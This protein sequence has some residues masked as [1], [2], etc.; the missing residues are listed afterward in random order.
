MVSNRNNI[1]KYIRL[2]RKVFSLETL[3]LSLIIC[4]SYTFHYISG[5]VYAL[6]TGVL[7]IVYILS[8]PT[9]KVKLNPLSSLLLIS[10]FVIVI[11]FLRSQRS[12]GSLMDVITLSC[13]VLLVLFC[14]RRENIYE[15]CIKIIIFLGVFFAFGVFIQRFL[16]SI[17]SIFLRIL[18]ESVASEIGNVPTENYTRGFSTNSG[19]TAYY[20]CTGIIAVMSS[21]NLFEGKKLR[22][23]RK[24]LL[25]IILIA[26]LLLALFY[27]G[28]RGYA[29]SLLLSL[30]LCYIQT[31]TGFE[32]VKRCLRIF[33]VVLV[34]IIL[35]FILHD[36][37][38]AVPLV[39]RTI[40]TIN[41]LIAGED[42]SNLRLDLYVW[43]LKLFAENPL[44]G[45]GWGNYRTTTV[46]NVTYSSDLDV[47]NNYLQLLCE[48][49]IIGFLCIVTTFVAFWMATKKA[50]CQCAKD[51]SI[52]N[53]AWKRILLFSY[54]YQTYF[55]LLGL[56][57][58]NLYDQQPQLV[59][60][61][62]CSIVVAY[63]LKRK[64]QS[65]E[66]P[67]NS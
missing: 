23:D 53:T 63:R 4:L 59:Y 56:T 11:S 15:Q 35:F 33:L 13:G 9:V 58:S 55:H 5:S 44:L 7:T 2:R 14:S 29:L 20:T 17:Y 36:F 49:G 32:K 52:G 37:L 66:I 27:T 47:H 51:Y 41:G 28:R 42:V 18:P 10:L 34:S 64:M 19:F 24:I 48:T 25:K 45:I 22:F 3:S 12:L 61:L 46:G 6:M 26:S 54:L 31:S 16:P 67:Y 65:K 38:V 43:A 1:I 30:F 21:M 39:K 60:M 62:A 50:Y 57:E 8:R 40:D